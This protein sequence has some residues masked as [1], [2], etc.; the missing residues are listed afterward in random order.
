MRALLAAKEP[1]FTKRFDWPA[2]NPVYR[3][4][5]EARIREIDARTPAGLH[6]VG[7]GFRGV[8]IPDCVKDARA[9]A[10]AIT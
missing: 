9:V 7:S 2:A 10:A 1:V 6:L 8:G 4:G 5:H 3:V